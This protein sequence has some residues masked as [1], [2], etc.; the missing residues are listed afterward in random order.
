MST[1][2]LSVEYLLHVATETWTWAIHKDGLVWYVDTVHFT[3]RE[4]AEEEMRMWYGH[5]PETPHFK[6]HYGYAI[7]KRNTKGLIVAM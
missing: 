1:G 5:L 3:S 2:E 7:S 6:V 4:K